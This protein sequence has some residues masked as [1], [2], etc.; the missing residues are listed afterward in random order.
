MI[1]ATE[2]GKPM[3]RM[4]CMFGVD[5]KESGGLNSYLSAIPFSGPFRAKTIKNKAFFI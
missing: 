4:S 1:L 5:E 2:E 3:A